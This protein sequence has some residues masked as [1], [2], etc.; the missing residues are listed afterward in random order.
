ML[1]KRNGAAR[2]GLYMLCSLVYSSSEQLGIDFSVC[3]HPAQRKGVGC[4]GRELF[5]PFRVSVLLVA[6]CCFP[7]CCFFYHCIF[8]LLDMTHTF[9]WERLRHSWESWACVASIQQAQSFWEEP[10]KMLILEGFVCLGFFWKLQYRLYKCRYTT[11]S[12]GVTPFKESVSC[13]NGGP[14][15]MNIAT[16]F[17]FIYSQFSLKPFPTALWTQPATA[18]WLCL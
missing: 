6:A 9:T 2:R 18:Q 13:P 11:K 3:V 4:T 8:T 5:E 14:K 1:P 15:F 7:P 12:T 16:C 17:S 10:E